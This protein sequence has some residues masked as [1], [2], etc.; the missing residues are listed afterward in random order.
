MNRAQIVSGLVK[1]AR[2]EPYAYGVNDCFFLG[3]K[4]I[5]ALQGTSHV[6]AFSGAYTTLL[7]ANR[8]LRKRGHKSIVTLYSEM[9]EPIA[10]GQSCIGD[11]AV[12]E[13]DGA[14]HVAVNGGQAWHSITEAGPR[15]W[16]LHLA[17]C[18]FKV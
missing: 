9:V 10:W 16:P 1:T 17:K 18:A 15:S 8:A 3:L 2:K 11:L 7:G 13:V 5:D 4:V 12:V 6:K 14:E